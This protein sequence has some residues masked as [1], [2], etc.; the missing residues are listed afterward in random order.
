MLAAIAPVVLKGLEEL[1][2]LAGPALEA[3]AKA[4]FAAVKPIIEGFLAAQQV[5]DLKA[6]LTDEA[7]DDVN[8]ATD[9]AEDLKLASVKEKG[10]G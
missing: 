8:F 3:E 5:D 7:R 10:G 4:V 2:R 9:L 1:E 6:D